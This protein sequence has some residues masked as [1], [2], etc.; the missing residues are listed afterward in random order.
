MSANPTKRK[1]SNE[2]LCANPQEDSSKPDQE[3]KSNTELDV[4]PGGSKENTEYPDGNGKV[5]DGKEGNEKKEL[6]SMVSVMMTAPSNREN[7]DSEHAK[8]IGSV[9]QYRANMKN[10]MNGLI[11]TKAKDNSICMATYGNISGNNI[12]RKWL[13]AGRM[14]DSKE[15]RSGR[16]EV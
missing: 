14:K 12:L 2:P 6:R 1:R 15:G 3:K 9:R 13:T 11:S 7:S 10:R 5:E 4:Q 16:M 8:G